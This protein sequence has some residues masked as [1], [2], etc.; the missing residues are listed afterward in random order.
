MSEYVLVFTTASQKDDAD[1]IANELVKRGLAACVQ[2]FSHITSHY[3]WK[4]K[5]ESATEWLCIIKTKASI[6]DELEAAIKEIHTYETPEIVAVDMVRGSQE[7]LAWM[8][9]VLEK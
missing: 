5:V 8:D 1:R 4:D 6:Y 3:R 2:V 7:Y 9:E